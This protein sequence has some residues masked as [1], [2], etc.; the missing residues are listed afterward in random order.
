MDQTKKKTKL[1]L[2]FENNFD[3]WKEIYELYN[4]TII[5]LIETGEIKSEEEINKQIDNIV[6]GMKFGIDIYESTKQPIKKYNINEF[7]LQIRELSIK[8]LQNFNKLD[9]NFFFS[10]KN[11]EIRRIMNEVFNSFADKLIIFSKEII[12]KNEGSK[13]ENLIKENETLK[14]KVYL[15]QLKINK[16]EDELSITKHKFLQLQKAVEKEVVSRTKN[17]LIE[18]DQKINLLKEKLDTIELSMKEKSKIL[19]ESIL[20]IKADFAKLFDAYKTIMFLLDNKK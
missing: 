15:Y 16:L 7:D 11:T 8:N 3:K 17:I 18:K 12:E 14:N 13:S 20:P 6:D 19:D 2:L 5:N 4:K 9:K 1:D 10:D